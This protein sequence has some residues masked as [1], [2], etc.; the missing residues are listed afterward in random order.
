MEVNCEF[1]DVRTADS[2]K[3]IAERTINAS[4]AGNF[5]RKIQTHV[6]AGN[7]IL[8]D[9]DEEMIVVGGRQSIC[10]A[11]GQT[12]V[13]SYI[14]AAMRGK[15]I[16]ASHAASSRK[17]WAYTAAGMRMMQVISGPAS[18]LVPATAAAFRN[19]SPRGFAANYAGYMRQTYSTKVNRA[20]AGVVNQAAKTR[21][22]LHLFAESA[23]FGGFPIGPQVTGASLSLQLAQF[24][25]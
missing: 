12:P 1:L 23:D 8:L 17:R 25:A 16:Y 13:A 14:F 6:T 22:V 21:T 7:L 19:P 20:V 4:G 9:D 15:V 3:T 5:K 11:F 24:F 10:E 2:T 18:A